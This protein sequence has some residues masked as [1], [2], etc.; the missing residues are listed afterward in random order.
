MKWLIACE[1]SGLIRD[2][3]RELGIE[4]WSC[5]LFPSRRPSP[6]HLE[7]DVR[8]WLH[9]PWDGLVAMP[10][11]RY[12]T[13]AGVRWLHERPERWQLMEEGCAFYNLFRD[14][15]HIPRRAIEN[16]VQYPYA[17]ERTGHR[18][19]KVRFVHPFHFGDPFQKATGWRT[20]GLLPLKPTHQ[21]SDYPEGSIRQEAWL[22]TPSE[23]REEKRSETKPGTAREVA[24]Q[25]GLM[26]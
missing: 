26:T 23:D 13:N 2:A 3:M 1:R 16:P 7:G 9:L 6:Y 20:F 15:T 5:D 11:C 8:Q 12:L 10:V 18:A 17:A 22:M 14:A 4:A 25:W 24:R 21:R 19:P